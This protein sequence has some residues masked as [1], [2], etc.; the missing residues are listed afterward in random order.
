M[1]ALILLL[2]VLFPGLVAACAHMDG[3]RA[4]APEREP[5]PV[6]LV[7]FEERTGYGFAGPWGLRGMLLPPEASGEPWRLTGRFQFDTA[8]YEVGAPVVSVQKR[9]PE[10]V[11]ITLPVA[12][13]PA[14][15]MVAQVITE[16]PF[17]KDIPV[18]SEAQFQIDIQPSSGG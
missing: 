3:E 14:D 16:I 11:T 8:G 1:R 7:P 5:I 13:P 6:P 12:E 15:A 4:D 18:S 2:L 17:E 9:Y 10:A